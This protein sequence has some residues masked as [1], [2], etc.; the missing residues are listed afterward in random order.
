MP[1]CAKK[2]AKKKRRREERRGGGKTR[3]ARSIIKGNGVHSRRWS[4]TSGTERSC[5]WASLGGPPKWSDR[6]RADLAIFF[7]SLS[8]LAS[9]S[10]NSRHFTVGRKMLP[11]FMICTFVCDRQG[12]LKDESLIGTFN[13]FLGGRS[14]IQRR[15][16]P[17]K[18]FAQPRPQHT[19]SGV[20]SGTAEHFGHNFLVVC[21]P[22]AAVPQHPTATRGL[23]VIYPQRNPFGLSPSSQ[24][25]ATP[26]GWHLVFLL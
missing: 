7:S 26:S 21:N 19:E 1:Y 20:L 14:V 23:R 6:P 15:I 8:L 12:L 22:L 3:D 10:G 13:F 17:A 25:C 16:I 9:F 5:S 2:S 4:S 24:I 11:I 18:K